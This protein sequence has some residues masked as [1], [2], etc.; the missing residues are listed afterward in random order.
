MIS[1]LGATIWQ[2]ALDEASDEHSRRLAR[3]LTG[4]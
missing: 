2:L 1:Q 4:A 3:N